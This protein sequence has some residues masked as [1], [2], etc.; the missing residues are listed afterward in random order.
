MPL[1]LF[2]VSK[3]KLKVFCWEFIDYHCC[4]LE[5]G[6][7]LKF[8]IYILCKIINVTCHWEASIWAAFKTAEAA[9]TNYHLL[10]V[11]FGGMANLK[12]AG[13]T[14]ASMFNPN[15]GSEFHTRQRSA[16]KVGM[17]SHT[18]LLQLEFQRHSSTP[19][20]LNN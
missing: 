5:Y 7:K 6:R 14:N 3:L 13:K 1:L 19:G 10:L 20:S 8:G 11:I 17:D 18:P 15:T 9:F 2:C 12:A 4:N 16:I